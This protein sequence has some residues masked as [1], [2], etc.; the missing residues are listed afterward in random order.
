LASLP[1][2]FF[3]AFNVV[4]SDVFGIRKEAEAVLYVLAS[5]GLL[6]LLFGAIGHRTG[7]GWTLWLSYTG[8]LAVLVSLFDNPNRAV[9]AATVI[10]AVLAGAAVGAWLGSRI[11]AR[12]SALWSSG[13][14]HSRS[15]K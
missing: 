7:V 1:W 10:T 11:G 12:L 3:V 14:D 9:Y 13:R 8:V 5:Y 4:F 15:R 2:A 6:G